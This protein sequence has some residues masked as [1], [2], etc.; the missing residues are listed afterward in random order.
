MGRKTENVC[1]L[2]ARE[3][4]LFLLQSDQTVFAFHSTPH[5]TESGRH[6]NIFV[7]M[8]VL[9][10]PADVSYQRKTSYGVETQ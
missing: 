3:R 1:W 8:P 10:S 6:A 7:H 2:L 4:N 9:T 5:L